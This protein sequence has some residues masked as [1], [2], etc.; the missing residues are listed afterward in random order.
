MTLTS[1]LTPKEKKGFK[2]KAHHLNPIIVI[3][4]KG[5]TQS[6]LAETDVA[7]EHHELIKVKANQQDKATCETYAV[8]ICEKLK[9]AL[10]GRVGKTL[11]IY[12]KS[13]KQ[14]KA[15][16]NDKQKKPS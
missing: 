9:A 16:Q 7:L 1:K 2:S 4:Q 5:L 6:V 14:K 3:G 12:R 11:I 15:T 10:V 13:Q 8:E